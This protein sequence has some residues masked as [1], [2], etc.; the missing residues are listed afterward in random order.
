MIKI[1]GYWPEK[2]YRSAL[3]FY[4]KQHGYDFEQAYRMVRV[5][6]AYMEVEFHD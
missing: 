2:S 1:K 5:I 6:T 3:N 4:R